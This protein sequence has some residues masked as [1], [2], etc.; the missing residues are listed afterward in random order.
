MRTLVTAL[1]LSI[2]WAAP[3]AEAAQPTEL[4]PFLHMD[5]EVGYNGAFQFGRL[6]EQDPDDDTFHDVAKYNHAHHELDID[7]EFGVCPMLELDLRF[8]IVFQDRLH[9]RSANEL[10]Y[11]AAENKATMLDQNPMPSDE[12]EDFTRA[13]FDDMWIG[14]QFSPFNEAYEDNPSPATVLFEFA[15]SPPTGK[16]RYVVD[17]RG[18][19]APGGGGPDIRFGAAFSKRVKGSEPYIWASY[20]LTGRYE[21][22]LA[23]AEGRPTYSSAAVL[24]PADSVH[25]RF[26]AELYA[27]NN[28]SST[29]AINVDIFGGF[30]YYTWS[31]IESGSILPVIHPNTNGRLATTSEYLV[32]TFGLGLYI[33]P[34]PMVQIRLNAGV[35]YETSHFIERV[36]AHNY[37]IGTGVDTLAVTFGLTVAGSFSPPR[38]AGVVDASS[39]IP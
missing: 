7:I 1:L 39:P 20:V 14:L 32:P 5:T 34:T 33:R 10:G 27:L 6:R 29:T 28:P 3:P 18:K 12:L 37:D 36:D 8:P 11:D 19:A 31:D 9:Y 16:S 17:S 35:D 25:V 38:N 30:T 4:I 26:G 13:G 23:D 15:V 24:N 21:V 2:C 22:N